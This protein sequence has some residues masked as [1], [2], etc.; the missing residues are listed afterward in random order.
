MTVA[1][2]ARSS[3]SKRRLLALAVALA[4]AA[5]VFLSLGRLLVSTDP[6]QHADA[7]Y[8]LGGGWINR[9]YEAAMIYRDGYAPRIV[10][11]PDRTVDAQIALERQGIHYPT[12][13]EIARQVLTGPL[14]IPES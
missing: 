3:R 12:D 9:T 6:L 10:L 14:K 4:I 2:P 1:L 7:I 11:S 5:A 8:V 13:P